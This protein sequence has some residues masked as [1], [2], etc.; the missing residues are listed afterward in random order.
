MT[1]GD[2]IRELNTEEL[3]KI[4]NISPCVVEGDMCDH[5]S[6]I[7]CRIDWLNREYHEIVEAH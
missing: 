6:C 2:R 4:I 7:E 5:D 3:A 1:N